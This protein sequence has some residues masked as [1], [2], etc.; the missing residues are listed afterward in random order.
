MADYR[1]FSFPLNAYA[2]VLLL[3]TGKLD[4]LHYG[5]FVHSGMNIQ[6]AQEYSTEILIK[7]LPPPPCSL[8]EVGIG[9]GA[10]LKK[11]GD[12]GYEVCGI[13]PDP[14]RI[15]FAA[16]RIKGKAVL[17]CSRWEQYAP[18]GKKFKAFKA[19]VFQESSQYVD[20][21]DL[22]N[23]AFDLLEPGGKL[24]VL[25]EVALK[26]LAPGQEG[27]HLLKHLLELAQYCGFHLE[28]QLDL[29][30]QASPTV[31]FLLG[32]VEKY[33]TSLEQE[34]GVSSEELEQLIQS[35][36]AYRKKYQ[37]GCY[38]Y[39]LLVFRKI[40]A[41]RWRLREM[42]LADR[43][44]VLNLFHVCFGHEMTAAMWIWKY[45]VGHAKDI[46]AWKGETLVGYYGG[47]ARSM[48]F[49]GEPTQVIQIGD[50]MVHPSERGTLTRK[51]VFFRMASTFFETNVGFGKRF[52]ASYGF[53][54][55]RV[56]QLGKSLGLYGELDRIIEL[57]WPVLSS[58]LPS[59]R[60]VLLR[61]NANDKHFRQQADFLWKR[62]AEHLQDA[63]VGDRGG[64]YLGWR[65]F[66][67]PCHQYHVLM[68]LERIGDMP[69]GIVVLRPHEESWELM[70]VV[71][72]LDDIPLMLWHAR[73][74][75]G[76][77]GGKRLFG[78]VTSS[79]Q[80]HFGSEF[81]SRDIGVSAASNISDF[82]PRIEE[83]KNRWWLTSGD[84]DSH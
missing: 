42:V 2:H 75:V 73:R 70:D 22:F 82:G 28:T 78:W 15:A 54:N 37:E 60:S 66:E 55:E 56:M 30:A 68:V 45:G 79:F 18:V 69:R 64:E 9:L 50:T 23:H 74:F 31:D 76:T 67:H 62:M 27:L 35:N 13:T 51:G 11:L 47:M 52:L 39:V 57:K 4:Y 84:T 6:E 7:Y 59:W 36:H 43:P 5:I 71:C 63:V 19:I 77:A 25:D 12:N 44:A 72:R 34:L 41:P 40:T 32:A 49:F 3:E 16:E 17:T 83:M 80:H 26:R 81:E 14:E 53:P 1:K 29:S 24:I 38:G 33:R 20:M 48:L 10:T 8:L 46:V 58:F 61:V 21:L 65:Y